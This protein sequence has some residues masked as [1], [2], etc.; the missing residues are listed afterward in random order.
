MIFNIF[1]DLHPQSSVPGG[2]GPL[3]NA[4]IYSLTTTDNGV[5]CVLKDNKTEV[6]TEIVQDPSSSQRRNLLQD[7]TACCFVRKEAGGWS[8]TYSL[9]TY[10]S[11]YY[12]QEATI[13]R[14]ETPIYK[15]AQIEKND[16]NGTF[17]LKVMTQDGLQKTAIM[18]RAKAKDLNKGISFPF[19][20]Q[21]V[22]STLKQ[23]HVRGPWRF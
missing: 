20:R 18:K 2:P 3:N 12:Y 7:N 8:D 22:N 23:V 16:L 10:T 21:M 17:V 1:N 6:E 5:S 11:N 4:C 9:W 13:E 15:Y 14:G 19:V